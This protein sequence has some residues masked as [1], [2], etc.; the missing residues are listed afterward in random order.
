MSKVEFANEA[1]VLTH[2]KKDQENNKVIIFEG[3]VYDVKAYMPDHPGGGDLIGEHLGKNIEEEFEDAEHTKYA[4]KLLKEQP[5]V[6]TVVK[7]KED[8]VKKEGAASK[9]TEQKGSP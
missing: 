9:A 1:A 7:S 4:K 5:Q 6:G 3:V 2:Y 8:P